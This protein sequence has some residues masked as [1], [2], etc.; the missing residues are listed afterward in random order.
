M[1]G[2]FADLIIV[3]SEHSLNLYELTSLLARPPPQ[4]RKKATKIDVIVKTEQIQMPKLEAHSSPDV[5]IESDSSPN[6]ELT[7]P[8]F[9]SDE[10]RMFKSIITEQIIQKK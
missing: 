10:I 2:E 7:P 6:L 1:E 4:K 8:Y 3:L 9:D 5:K